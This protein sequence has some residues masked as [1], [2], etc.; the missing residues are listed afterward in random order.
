MEQRAG[1]FSTFRRVAGL[2]Q[3]LFSALKKVSKTRRKENIDLCELFG[4]FIVRIL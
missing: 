3:S 1:A 2:G 4:F